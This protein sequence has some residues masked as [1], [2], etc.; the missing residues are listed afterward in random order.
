MDVA[1]GVV[2]DGIVD[3]GEV[4]LGVELQEYKNPQE[5]TRIKNFFIFCL[6]KSYILPASILITVTDNLL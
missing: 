4:G 1:R 2:I 6:T 5:I 3:S